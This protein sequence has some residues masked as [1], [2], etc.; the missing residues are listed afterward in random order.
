V[1]D[2]PRRQL[3]A[4]LAGASEVNERSAVAARCMLER[5]DARGVTMTVVGGSAVSIWDAGA[6]TSH[7]IDIV[8]AA[9]PDTIDSVLVTDLGFTRH[10]RHWFDE[11]LGLVVEV[12]GWS[13]EPVGAAF[14][15]VAGIRVIRLEDLILDR[16]NQWHATG[17]FEAWR[18]AARLLEHGALDDN[19][20]ALRARDVDVDDALE[21]VRALGMHQRSGAEIDPPLSHDVHRALELN[22]LD[23]VRRILR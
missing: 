2:T 11:E 20:L 19:Y 15:M 13:L 18:Q 3:E 17:S 6:H 5:F 21:S 10:G 14:D 12:P 7:D 4:A 8:G 1:S 23:G 16:V 22:G 9:W